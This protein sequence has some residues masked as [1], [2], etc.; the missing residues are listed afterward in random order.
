MINKIKIANKI[1]SHHSPIFIIAEAGVNHNG[2]L[3]LA[4]RMVDIAARS[5]ADAI[6]FQTFKAV[7]VVID[8]KESQLAMLRALELK[9][10][11]YEKIIKFCKKLGI[12]FLSTPHGGF[13][14]VD[15]LQKLKVSAFKFGSGDITNLPV[16]EYAAKFKKPMILG[17]GMSTL[18]EVKEAIK[19]IKKVGNNKIII[20]HC[21]TSYP[22][23]LG[24]V[25]LLAMQTLARELGVLSGYS[26]HTVGIQ[27]PIMA[28]TL[29]AC[30][31][32]KHFTLDKTL[33]GP[34]HKASLE[35][36]ELAAMTQAVRNAK[37]IL[38]SSGK[39]PTRNELLILKE[40][41]KSLATSSFVKKGDLFTAKN[42][43]IKRPGTGLQ[44]SL[45]ANVL[46]KKAKYNIGINE[47]ITK[48]DYE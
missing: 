4:L 46:G 8:K 29:G 1:I 36:H 23:P 10:E 17:T 15:W 24:E 11:Y 41:R 30:V 37:V 43:A 47:L 21:T 31:I 38:G 26:D 34:D 19:C 27:V 16:L 12:I 22:C 45:Y 20:L 14:S 5:G 25:N 35:P 9:E 2:R 42:L 32:E 44:P 39:K 6:K 7:D 48:H 3:D 28:A 13:S 40:A 33:A 18:I